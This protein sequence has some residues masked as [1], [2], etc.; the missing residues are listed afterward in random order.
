MIKIK[1]IKNLCPYT[2]VIV[3]P[4]LPTKSSKLNQRAVKCNKLFAHYILHDKASEGVRAMN[5]ESF[6]NSSGTLIETLSVWDTE[7]NQGNKNF[8]ETRI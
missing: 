1:D 5:F 7:N 8:K 6:V 4:I 2:T 3:S